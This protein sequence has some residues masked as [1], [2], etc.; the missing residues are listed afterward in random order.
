MV[1]HGGSSAGSYLAD[2]TSPIPCHCSSIVVTSILLFCCH[3]QN[4]DRVS[5]H[6]LDT[7]SSHFGQFYDR[8]L[9]RVSGPND[10]WHKRSHILWDKVLWLPGE[11]RELHL[12]WDVQCVLYICLKYDYNTP[13][14]VWMDCQ[15]HGASYN[16]TDCVLG[17]SGLN[18]IW[19]K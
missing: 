3:Q 18:E 14:H 8:C 5:L 7:S 1:G 4:C 10:S 11:T 12:P 17:M 16:M 9:L 13:A 6:P 2:P 19:H 15:L